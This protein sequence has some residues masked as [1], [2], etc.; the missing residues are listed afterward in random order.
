MK[1]LKTFLC[2]VSIVVL[3]IGC[4]QDKSAKT[5][6]GVRG[7]QPNIIWL[8]AEDQSPDFFPMYG[9]S[10]IALP[11]LE[12]LAKEGVTFMNAYSPVPVCAP[13]RS[14]IITGMYPTTLGTHNMRTYNA[15]AKD[16]QPTIG[17]PSYSPNV[18]QGVKMFTEYLR[19]AGYYCS[20]GPKEDYNF[21]KL[22]SAWDESGKEAHWR[23]RAKDQP[24]FSVFNFGVCHE[25]QIW[26]RGQDS[27]FVDPEKVPV[28]LYFPDNGI[29]RRDL[30]VNY[31]NLKRLDDQVG[32][33]LNQLKE[34]RLYDNSIIFFYGD[35]GGP[36]PRHKRALYES[37][38]KVPMIIKFP[39]NAK[40]GSRDDRFFSFID[41][42][43]TVLSLAGIEPPRVMQGKAQFG[44]FEA[45]QKEKYTFHSSDRFDELYDRLRSVR[46]RRYKYIKNFNPEI[47]NAMPVAYREQMPMMQNL[48]LLHAE[49]KLDSMQALWFQTPKPPEELYDLGNDPHELRNLAGN[50]ELQDTLRHL[51]SVLTDWIIETKDLG[52]YPEKELIAEWLPNGVSPQLPAL[53]MEARDTGIF[54]FSKK[55]DA[56][57]IWK[58]PQESTWQ[59]YAEP[60]PKSISFVAKAERLGYVESPELKYEKE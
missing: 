48:R 10:T 27:L 40:A 60:L 36:F 50:I 28:P 38:T 39:N 11:H 55:T 21:K 43:P 41:L 9:D 47:S 34:E 31:S 30:A 57:I 13:A 12:A 22:E 17:I 42:A 45:R 53:E 5:G 24:F 16:N 29:I 52:E 19:R 4:V 58:Q 2:E 7:Q 35:H 37:G 23:K 15:Y 1:T 56:T 32:T 54:L 26:A 59:I 33:I 6:N 49:G 51:R 8:V 25:S 14:A 20:N 46:S 44:P 3:A 18:P